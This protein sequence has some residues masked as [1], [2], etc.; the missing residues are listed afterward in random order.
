M[1]KTTFQFLHRG[2][3]SILEIGK[4]YKCL[5]RTSLLGFLRVPDGTGTDGENRTLFL[6]TPAF[7]RG[8][9]RSRV[10][11]NGGTGVGGT[12]AGGSGALGGLPRRGGVWAMT[13]NSERTGFNLSTETESVLE[14][15]WR[16]K[17]FGDL[18]T[19][20]YGPL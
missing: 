11:G 2:P 20:R 5:S 18:V 15:I 6:G 12:G 9:G 10:G 3:P 1:W 7:E 16:E 13:V 19:T 8:V 4:N 14:P 17:Y